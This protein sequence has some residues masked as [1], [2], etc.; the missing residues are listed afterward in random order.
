MSPETLKKKV[1]NFVPA[2]QREGFVCWDSKL[3]LFF[4]IIQRFYYQPDIS[5]FG[6]IITRFDWLLQ[7]KLQRE[8]VQVEEKSL[9]E[10][11]IPKKK[12]SAT[13]DPNKLAGRLGII[14]DLKITHIKD[15]LKNAFLIEG[16][17]ESPP[18]GR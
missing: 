13:S 11:K 2:I 18:T 3:I 6:S 12:R 16:V 17:L 9:L 7:E 4:Y 8:M 14:P 1:Q 10:R 15:H 5:G